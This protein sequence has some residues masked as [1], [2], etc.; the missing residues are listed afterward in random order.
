M[1]ATEALVSETACSLSYYF[2]AAATETDAEM[3]ETAAAISSGCWS[4]SPAADAA[5]DSVSDSAEAT[6]DAAV[7]EK[8]K[9]KISK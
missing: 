8:T 2:A 1:D 7:D 5:T 4:S 6:T 9:R 3:T